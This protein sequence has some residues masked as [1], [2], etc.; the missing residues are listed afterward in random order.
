[1]AMI[2]GHPGLWSKQTGLHKLC[3]WAGPLDLF[4]VC[5]HLFPGTCFLFICNLP[6]KTLSLSSSKFWLQFISFLSHHCLSSFN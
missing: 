4:P 5:P 2:V 3:F 6:V 1:M